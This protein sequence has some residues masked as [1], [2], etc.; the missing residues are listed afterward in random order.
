MWDID[1]PYEAGNDMK[2]PEEVGIDFHVSE[3]LGHKVT[4]KVIGAGGGEIVQVILPLNDFR[5]CNAVPLNKETGKFQEK[6]EEQCGHILFFCPELVR[7]NRK[8]AD[9]GH[10]TAY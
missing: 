2:I 10:D 9:N 6:D 1:N 7:A 5:M 4:P 8:P 3:E